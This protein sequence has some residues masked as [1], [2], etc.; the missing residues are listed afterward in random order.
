MR[1][2]DELQQ[3]AS[4]DAASPDAQ[5][6]I[7]MIKVFIAATVFA[8]SGVSP[9]AWAQSARQQEQRC[10][11]S[12]LNIIAGQVGV[13]GLSY[14][15]DPASTDAINGLQLLAGACKAWPRGTSIVIAAV[16]YDDESEEN[17]QQ[18][19]VVAMVD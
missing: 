11:E 4:P 12:T 7:A 9:C 8:C 2:G 16:A 13:D 1:D 19:L 6:S 5:V 15:D 18:S 10:N 14:P 3:T 17:G